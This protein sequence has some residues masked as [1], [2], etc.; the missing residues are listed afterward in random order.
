VTEVCVDLAS[1]EER[2]LL[3]RLLEL[4]QHDFSGDTGADLGPDGTYGWRDLGR[5]WRE[6]DR[7]PFL[8]RVDGRLA[9]FALVHAGEPHDMAE[10]FV[11][12]KY[13]RAGVGTQA[14]TAVFARFPGGWQVRQQRANTTAT[15]FWRRAVPTGFTESETPEGPVQR[16]VV[17]TT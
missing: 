7:Y 17:P 11:V 16:F 2:D 15:A 1:L 3:A 8:V 13:R 12:R 5:W 6:P 10:F 14:A 4:Y 9:G